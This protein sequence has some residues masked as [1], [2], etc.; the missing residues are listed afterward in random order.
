MPSFNSRVSFFL[1][2]LQ[3]SVV[4]RLHDLLDV[5]YEHV[6]DNILNSEGTA[7]GSFSSA[8]IL[9]FRKITAMTASEQ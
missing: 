2:F 8:A 9:E 3:V 7:N 6:V 5:P 4:L 1:Q